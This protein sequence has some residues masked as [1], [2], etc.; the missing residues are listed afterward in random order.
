ME[1]TFDEIRR[2]IDDPDFVLVDVLSRESFVNGHIPGARSL[3][4]AEIPTRAA[5][6][7][8]DRTADVVVYCS[9]PT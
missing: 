2:R 8:P 9:K 7:L 1:P 3:P 5:E 6:V 4:L